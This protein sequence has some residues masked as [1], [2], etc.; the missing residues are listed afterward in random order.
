MKKS[1]IAEIYFSAFIHFLLFYKLNTYFLNCYL[2]VYVTICQSLE[3]LKI[4][5]GRVVGINALNIC[6][7]AQQVAWISPSFEM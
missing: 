7:F 6:P 3:H 2:S 5:E 1:S 4:G